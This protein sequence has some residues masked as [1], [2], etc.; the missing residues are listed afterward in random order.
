MRENGGEYKIIDGIRESLDRQVNELDDRTLLALK[1]MRL[2]AIDS[3]EHKRGFFGI[4]RWVSATG[5][6]TAVV[7]VAAVSL[8]FVSPR[9]TMQVKSPEEFEILSN[10]KEQQ[11]LYRDLDFYR[12]L[13]EEDAG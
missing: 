9:S 11:E 8:V 5:I 2:Q 10:S 12:W 13:A 4:P 7:L 6:A 3:L 1:S